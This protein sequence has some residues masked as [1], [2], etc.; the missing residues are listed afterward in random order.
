MIITGI[1][2]SVLACWIL[3]LAYNVARARMKY[4]IGLL[5][6]GNVHLTR[7]IR[8]HGN[9][10]EYL[11]IALIL[12]AIAET[13]GLP[14]LILHISGSFL[15]AFRLWHAWGIFHSSGL[16]K[17]RFGGTLGTWMI[18]IILAGYNIFVG[19]SGMAA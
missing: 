11:P 14:H 7:A 5:D 16:S 9:A 6:G 12:L 10:T 13:N 8:I 19:V 1:Y 18:I 15:V 3:V 17:G 4:R 2:A